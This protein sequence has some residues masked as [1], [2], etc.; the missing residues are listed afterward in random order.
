MII[1]ISGTPG[2]G[3]TFLAKEISKLNPNL[4]YFDLNKYIKDQKLYESYD[5]KAKTYDVDVEMLKK[6]VNP[7]LKKNLSENTILDSLIGK[8]LNV[9]SLLQKMK[10]LP[11][12]VEGII[13]DSHLSH[14]LESDYC[15]IVRTDLKKLYNRLNKRKYSK[16]KI[17]DNVESEIFE[18]CLDEA[19]KL[20]RNIIIVNN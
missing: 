19:R 11:K 12:N 13:V 6:I 14:Y 20:K 8:T 2:V 5:R 10:K 3:K 17:H 16:A 7:T 1:T 18:V 9:D 4:E 15:I